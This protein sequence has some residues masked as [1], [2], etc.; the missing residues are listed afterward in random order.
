MRGRHN[1]AQGN[2]IVARDRI[3]HGRLNVG[4]SA[5]ETAED[6]DYVVHTRDG[7]ECAAVP[8]NVGREVVAGSFRVAACEDFV[9]VLPR[10]GL[11]LGCSE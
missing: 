7:S 6:G 5:D 10:D 9:D 8:C 3:L 2:Q 1:E 4:Q 11:A